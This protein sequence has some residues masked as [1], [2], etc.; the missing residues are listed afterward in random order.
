MRRTKEQAEDTRRA[1]LK[2]AESL[3][4]DKGYENV[5]LSEI[6]AAAG[7][8]R[9]AL[10]WHFGNKQGL[11]FAIRDEMRL[12]MQDL[13][14]RL[15]EDS[16]LELDP[17][18]ALGEVISN[19]FQRLQADPR[20]RRIFKVLLCLDSAGDAE[21]SNDG[22]LFQRRLRMSLQTVFEAVARREKM[23]PPWTPASAALAF[24]A[25]VSGLINEWARGKTDFELVP[26]AEAFVHMI[27]SSWGLPIRLD[28]AVGKPG[29]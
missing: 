22:N 25:A 2:A 24:N 5:S 21:D 1:L 19:A 6:A 20:Q 10:H 29:T 28:E 3:F 15:S 11:L 14:E 26:D 17:L 9:G 16:R 8:T 7:L 23:P 12:P 27:L 18:Q 13:A 4:L